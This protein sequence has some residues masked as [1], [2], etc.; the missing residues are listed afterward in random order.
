LKDI[1]Q[2]KK[3]IG[4]IRVG[5]FQQQFVGFKIAFGTLRGSFMGGY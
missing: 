3:E 5:K 4:E 2:P 1:N